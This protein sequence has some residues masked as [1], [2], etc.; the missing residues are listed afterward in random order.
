MKKKLFLPVLFA[1]EIYNKLYK[2]AESI[3]DLA[4]K[5]D[6]NHSTLYRYVNQTDVPS[7]ENYIRVCTWLDVSLDKFV[8]NVR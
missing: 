5:L 8:R 1:N 6:I 3:T 2:D 7:L 4:K